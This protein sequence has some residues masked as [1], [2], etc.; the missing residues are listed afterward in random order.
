M[1]QENGLD[2]QM[3]QKSSSVNE[4][5]EILSQNH[6]SEKNISSCNIE[7]IIS[8]QLTSL[9]MPIGTNTSNRGVFLYEKIP[10]KKGEIHEKHWNFFGR[11]ILKGYFERYGLM[12]GMG[13]THY[14]SRAEGVDV[15]CRVGLLMP[16]FLRGVD[17]PRYM[18]CNLGP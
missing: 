17:C 11:R 13:D 12:F 2:C 14:R 3:F 4:P 10:R 18:P 7:E 9:K 1:Y 8:D 6:K 5:S 16:R 15:C